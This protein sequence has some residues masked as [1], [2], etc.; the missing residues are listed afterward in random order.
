ME[1]IKLGDVNLHYR[2][3]GDPGGKPIVFANSLGTDF[4]LWDK[5]IPL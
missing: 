5:L 3:E 2:I 1:M 4:R